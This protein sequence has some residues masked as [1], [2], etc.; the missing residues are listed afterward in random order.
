LK[1]SKNS[2]IER[3][4]FLKL[5]YVDFDDL[6]QLSIYSKSKAINEKEHIRFLDLNLNAYFGK[7]FV[8]MFGS[9]IKKIVPSKV[10]IKNHKGLINY[11]KFGHVVV[12]QTE[13]P[14]R[15]STCLDLQKNCI[16]FPVDEVEYFQKGK[17]YFFTCGD[18]YLGVDTLKLFNALKK[19]KVIHYLTNLNN[20]E[21]LIPNLFASKLV[22]FFGLLNPS[23]YEVTSTTHAYAN[24]K[25][26]K[27][28]PLFLKMTL[29]GCLTPTK[30][31]YLVAR[32]ENAE[33]ETY[34]EWRTFMTRQNVR[35]FF[36]N[37]LTVQSVGNYVRRNTENI[38][39]EKRNI[40][41]KSHV[42]QKSPGETY[43]VCRADKIKDIEMVRKYCMS[44]N[45]SKAT[46]KE[47]TWSIQWAIR[48]AIKYESTSD[49]YKLKK[50]FIE[51]NG[52]KERYTLEDIEHFKLLDI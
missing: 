6:C 17:Y 26:I 37:S 40:L 1:A 10:E 33:N 27:L 38:L 9:K 32:I 49:Y 30:A 44:I 36:S 48:N 50:L 21:I 31:K 14:I 20:I 2:K 16:H 41:A 42:L 24:I 46:T 35:S 28:S 52:Q 43:I 47:K 12:G 15:L 18:I 29:R 13:E 45:T 11:H 8:L 5:N 7:L 22:S 3:T 4:N 51:L 25:N 23:T 19:K 34:F 39:S